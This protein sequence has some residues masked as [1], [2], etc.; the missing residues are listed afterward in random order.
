[1]SRNK[2]LKIWFSQTKYLGCHYS[3]EINYISIYDHLASFLNSTRIYSLPTSFLLI[4]LKF[5]PKIKRNSCK[6][7][8]L[9]YKETDVLSFNDG[10]LYI[11]R[12]QE[13]D[14]EMEYRSI[15]FTAPEYPIHVINRK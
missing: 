1:M 2:R 12:I 5:R 9:Y 4:L 6:R 8:R 13:K 14:D 11:E 3:N 10:K 15:E 7:K